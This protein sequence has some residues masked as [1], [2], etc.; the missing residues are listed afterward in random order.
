MEKHEL[1]VS[2][3][4]T[5]KIGEWRSATPIAVGSENIHMLHMLHWGYFG[6]LLGTSGASFG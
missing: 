4:C 5:L 1:V 3:D 6:D 2:K